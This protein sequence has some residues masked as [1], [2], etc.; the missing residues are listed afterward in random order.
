VHISFV[1]SASCFLFSLILLVELGWGQV[2][3]IK[4]GSSVLVN[5]ATEYLIDE[6]NRSIEEIASLDSSGEF[7]AYDAANPSFGRLNAPL[8]VRFTLKNTDVKDPWLYV[9]PRRLEYLTLYWVEN[10]EWRMH[11]SGG[12]LPMNSR[13]LPFKDFFFKVNIPVESEKSF[14]LK[15]E[16]SRL[17][18]YR[19]HAG[20]LADVV[21]VYDEPARFFYMYLGFVLVLILYNSI[22]SIIT[23]KRDYVYYT[24]YLF[25]LLIDL[26]YLQGYAPEIYHSPYLESINDVFSALFGSLLLIAFSNIVEMKELAPRLFQFRK[27][28]IAGLLT[29]GIFIPLFGNEVG[30][31]IIF[32]STYLGIIWASIATVIMI[33]QKNRLGIVFLLAFLSFSLGTLVHIFTIKGVMPFNFFTG[34][35]LVVGSVAEALLMTLAISLQFRQEILKQRSQLVEMNDA[36]MSRNSALEQFTHFITNTLN[37]PVNKLRNSLNDIEMKQGAS[38]SWSQNAAIIQTG[39]DQIRNIVTE[40]NM[41]VEEGTRTPEYQTIDPK[42]LLE[43]CFEPFK[44]QF[45]QAGA[46]FILGSFPQSITSEPS[47]FKQVCERILG[48]CLKN[49][50]NKLLLKVEAQLHEVDSHYRLIFKCKGT[51]AATGS[52]VLDGDDLVLSELLL[53]KVG[54]RLR[55]Q[56][57]STGTQL[58]AEI[59]KQQTVSERNILQ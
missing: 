31:E 46:T 40:I 16:S 50:D 37:E 20:A 26:A 2:V 34:Q 19:I 52:Q 9:T 17:V 7:S 36:L 27:I 58:M 41:V 23:M 3:E 1:K 49:R 39:T 8:W 28:L 55:M 56:E 47:V 5:E 29:G 14:F 57:H 13:H 38:S 48:F 6:E 18:S 45:E 35:A 11:E 51:V 59:P 15:I 22:L 44:I 54:G 24:G 32:L 21:E 25:F 30:V 4:G 10:G 12:L 43:Q 42:K 33:L 53:H